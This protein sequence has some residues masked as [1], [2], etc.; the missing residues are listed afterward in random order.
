MIQTISSVAAMRSIS[1]PVISDIYYLTESGKQGAFYYDASDTISTDNLGTIIVSGSYRF[2]RIYSQYVNALWFGVVADA[3][4]SGSYTVSGTDNTAAIQS[5]IDFMMLNGGG[6]LFFPKGS[7]LLNGTVY[8][9]P[10]TGTSIPFTLLGEAFNNRMAPWRGYGGTVFTRNMTGDF[11]KVNLD[12]YNKSVLDPGEQWFNF[13]ALNLSFIGKRVSDSDSLIT[14]IN[15]FHMFRT[16]SNMQN[17][18]ATNIDY[19]VYQEATDANNKE[20]YCDQSIYK[21]FYVNSPTLGGLQ[22]YASDSSIIETLN[23][24]QDPVISTFKNLIKVLNSDAVSIRNIVYWINIKDLVPAPISGSSVIDISNCT[25]TIISSVHLEHLIN[26]FTGIT[27]TGGSSSRCEG[28]HVRFDGN[29]TFKI[30]STKGLVIDGLSVSKTNITGYYDINFI[31]SNNLN[32]VWNNINILTS[33]T[34][35]SPG[36]PRNLATSGTRGTYVTASDD[37]TVVANDADY[38]ASSLQ[39]IRLPNI[40]ANRFFNLPNATSCPGQK[41]VIWNQNTSTLYSWSF[42]GIFS[43]KNAAGANMTTITNQTI[44]VLESYGTTNWVQIN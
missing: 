4:F 18:S 24:E 43:A 10:T 37:V 15:G 30:G 26:V 22:L 39:F 8:F 5:A 17:I 20:N 27:I 38:Y 2:K 35:G 40:T 7:Y 23:C 19:A 11:F 42:G 21:N 34:T 16:R 9:K 12:A 41:I 29:D 36:V 33:P 31:D 28:I 1:S 25:N 32:V 13:A 3:I 14:G 6:T 44:I